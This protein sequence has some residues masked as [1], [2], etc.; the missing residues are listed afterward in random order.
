MRSAS[1]VIVCR[2]LCGCVCPLAP[3]LT[4][5]VMLHRTPCLRPGAPST[6]ENFRKSL[7]TPPSYLE[8]VHALGT[9]Q[10][11]QRLPEGDYG[12]HAPLGT[13]VRSEP[14]GPLEAVRAANGGKW[15]ARTAR[16]RS[17]DCRASRF[18]YRVIQ[19]P[20]RFLGLASSLERA[21]VMIDK[22]NNVLSP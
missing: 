16:V 15:P 10:A 8:L 3:K 18:S 2:Y 19:M 7:D 17:H 12:R 22:Q 21:D 1:V 6:P 5:P 11:R 9:M 14:P 4:R 20:A 13:R